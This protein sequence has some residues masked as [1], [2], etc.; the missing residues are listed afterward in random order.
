MKDIDNQRND[1][2]EFKQRQSY[3]QLNKMTEKSFFSPILPELDLQIS[4]KIHI[5]N[6][7]ISENEKFSFLMCRIDSRFRGPP[8][9]RSFAIVGNLFQK[10]L[11]SERIFRI[12]SSVN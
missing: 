6:P 10:V 4:L 9:Q 1:R 7:R 3:C 5:G 8:Y 11:S 2:I 12:G